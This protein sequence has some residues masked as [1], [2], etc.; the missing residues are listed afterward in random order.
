MVRMLT[1]ETI[2][3][4]DIPGICVAED[5]PTCEGFIGGECDESS[6]LECFDYPGDGCDPDN[7]GAD[8]IGI[9]L[10]PLAK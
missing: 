1:Y 9:C 6:G 2:V 10:Y 7:G 4:C 5:A 3:A 8:C